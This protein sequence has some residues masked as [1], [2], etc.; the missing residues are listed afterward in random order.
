MDTICEHI[1][2]MGRN[3][4]SL[5]ETVQRLG[6]TAARNLSGASDGVS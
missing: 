5:P 2:L 6:V 4:L 1:N 3:A